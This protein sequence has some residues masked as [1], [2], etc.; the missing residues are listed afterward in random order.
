[1]GLEYEGWCR[2]IDLDF[3][4]EYP[5]FQTRIFK[6]NDMAFSICLTHPVENFLEIKKNFDRSIRYMTAPVELIQETPEH[7]QAEVHVITDDQ[8]PATFQGLL[9]TIAQLYNHIECLHSHLAVSSIIE[10]HSEQT[11]TVTIVEADGDDNRELQQTLDQ[12]KGPYNFLIQVG[13]EVRKKSVA[14][15]PIFNIASAASQKYLNAEY[16]ERDERLWYENVEDIYSGSFSKDALY[17]YNR[18]ESSC[19]VNC[20]VFKNSNLRNHL[21]LY[22]TI[23]CVLPLRGN[24]LTFL[25]DQK[26]NREDLLYL[27]EKGRLKFVNFQPEFRLDAGFLNEAYN[28]NNSAVISRRAIA[29]LSAI[30]LVELNRSYI[31]CDTEISS[32]LDPFVKELSKLTNLPAETTVKFLLWPRSALRSSFDNLNS[33]GPMGIGRYGINKPIT[34]S[35]TNNEKEKYEFEFF[36]YSG[37]T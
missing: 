7:F 16:L 33:A 24:M 4:A 27:V 2:R 18:Y 9:L 1:M 21:L 30:D 22:D 37:S 5:Q 13:G 10:N 3:R 25:E 15:N 23:Y 28:V 35:I 26:L 20:S 11:I 34:A 31:F 36:A 6:I 19:L 32:M 14:M 17:F 8:I 29:A 12:L